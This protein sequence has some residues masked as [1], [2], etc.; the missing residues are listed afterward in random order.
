LVGADDNDDGRLALAWAAR[1]AKAFSARLIVVDVWENP[2]ELS[3][4]VPYSSQ[5]Q[6][7]RFQQIA[8]LL[9]RTNVEIELVPAVGDPGWQHD[10]HLD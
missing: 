6:N 9:G 10:R 1:L 4:P 8:A 2:A 5:Q 3:G 7:Q